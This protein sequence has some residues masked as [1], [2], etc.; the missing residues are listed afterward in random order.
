MNALF[1]TAAAASSSRGRPSLDSHDCADEFSFYH[2]IE[3]CKLVDE[4]DAPF[5]NVGP[6]DIDQV[7]ETLEEVL[8][9]MEPATAY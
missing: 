2:W 3:V 4:S 9:E 6:P 5:D 7:K 1:V 8:S